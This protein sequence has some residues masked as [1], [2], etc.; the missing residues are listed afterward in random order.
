MAVVEEEKP[1]AANAT[2]VEAKSKDDN[3]ATDA[4]NT[5]KGDKDDKDVTV[6]EDEKQKQAEQ[7]TE[8]T[9]ALK[10]KFTPKAMLKK[11]VLRVALIWGI[12][13]LYNQYLKYYGLGPDGKPLPLSHFDG[14]ASGGV[15]AHG[16][17]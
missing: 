11:V 15:G 1:V 6:T 4:A 13:F 10:A 14:G 12:M 16:E 2:A 8:A 5:D 17:L 7:E 9:A 3:D